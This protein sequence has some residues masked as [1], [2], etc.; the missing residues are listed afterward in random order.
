[1]PHEALGVWLDTQRE[2]FADE[3]CHPGGAIWPILSDETPIIGQKRLPARTPF[4]LG[5]VFAW[6]RAFFAI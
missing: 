6:S 3:S 1:M 2:C 4:R 5:M